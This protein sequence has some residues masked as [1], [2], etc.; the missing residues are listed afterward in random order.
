MRYRQQSGKRISGGAG[1]RGEVFRHVVGVGL[2]EERYCLITRGVILE[3]ISDE[4][5]AVLAVGND[6]RPLASPDSDAVLA[7]VDKPTR[8]VSLRRPLVDVLIEVGGYHDEFPIDGLD[9]E[10]TVGYDC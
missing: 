3:L 2:P 5:H 8:L 4:L 10:P 7:V 1:S 6:L 9:V